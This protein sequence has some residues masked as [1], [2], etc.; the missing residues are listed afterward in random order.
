MIKLTNI[1]IS[2]NQIL[3]Y[4]YVEDCN[5]PI[6]LA[7]D[8]SSKELAE[9]TLPAGYEWCVNH[10]RYARRYL[11]SLIGLTELPTEKTIMWV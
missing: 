3:C 11:I 1:R 6:E 10:I 7:L 5:Q 9:Y 4:A 2:E 8:I